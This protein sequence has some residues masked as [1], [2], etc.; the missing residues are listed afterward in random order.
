MASLWLKQKFSMFG[1]DGF[2]IGGGARYIGKS[3]STGFS[4]YTLKSDGSYATATI[5]TPSFMLYDAM[6]AWEDKH[7]RFQINVQNIGDTIHVTTCLARGDCFYGARRTVLS[8]L[9]YKF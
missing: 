5:E 2:S 1:I 8:S 7:W 4:P 3:W 6:F 9:I